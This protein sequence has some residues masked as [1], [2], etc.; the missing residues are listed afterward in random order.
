M[1]GSRPLA[2]VAFFAPLIIYADASRERKG[3]GLGSEFTRNWEF[4]DAP[5]NN[6]NPASKS[7]GLREL[8]VLK[9]RGAEISR[10]KS[11]KK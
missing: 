5:L 10:I 9:C 7:I 2:M 3:E 1:V 8:K 6:W 4:Q 11:P